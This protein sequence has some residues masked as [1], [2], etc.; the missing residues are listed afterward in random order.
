M[1]MNQ[2]MARNYLFESE[3]IGFGIWDENDLPLALELW[4]DEEVTELIGGPFDTGRIKARLAQEIAN[5]N[6]YR[7]Q[8]WPMF[9]K[10]NGA[11]IGCCGLK[12]YGDDLKVLETGFH[13]SKKYWG[14]GYATEAGRRVLEYAFDELGTDRVVAGHNPLNN[15]SKHALEKLGFKYIGDEFYEPTGLMHLLYEIRPGGD[16]RVKG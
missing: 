4:G 10:T 2:N 5:H 9:L 7:I 12:P 11:F 1:N 6:E 3:R 15:K 16:F 14:R 8:Y 13:L